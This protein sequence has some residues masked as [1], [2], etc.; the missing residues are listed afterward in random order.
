MK[1]LTF[2]S[3]KGGVG[4]TALLM[5]LAIQWADR[6][7]VVAV[8][9]MDLNAPGLSFH[10]WMDPHE[11]AA[12]QDYGTSDLLSTY[13]ANRDLE[14]GTFDFFPPSRLLR[15]V[16]PADGDKWGS[17]GRLLALPAGRVSLPQAATFDDITQHK[18]PSS[19]SSE[20]G[21][22]DR[23]DPERRSLRAFAK[24]FRED[25]AQF[26][27]PGSQRTID[28]LLIDCRTGYPDLADLAMGYLADRIVLVAGLN[29]Q[30]LKGLKLTLETLRPGRIPPGRFA[31]DA[32]VVF[33]PVSAHWRDSSE[34][35]AAI[36]EG[37]GVLEGA[38]L[39]L[40]DFE[41]IEKLPP[42][43]TLPYTPHLAVSDVPV[44]RERFLGRLH[45]YW[46][47]VYEIASEL[48]P[49]DLPEELAFDL[50]RKVKNLMGLDIVQIVEYWQKTDVSLKGKEVLPTLSVGNLPLAEIMRLPK[51]HWPLA[52]DREK[53]DQWYAKLPVKPGEEPERERFLD[54]LCASA[55]LG[56]EG[57][58]DLI[59]NWPELS[60]F[61]KDSL[62][63]ILAEEQTKLAASNSSQGRTILRRLAQS[64]R[65]WARLVLEDEKAGDRAM[66]YWPLEGRQ[67]FAAWESRP[68]YWFWLVENLV[69]SWPDGAGPHSPALIT[70]V[71]PA[72]VHLEQLADKDFSGGIWNDLGILLCDSLTRYNEA[73]SAY[74]KGLA[75]NAQS[76]Y[77]L[78]NLA[79]L[80]Y[81]V[82][83][84]ND[85]AESLYRR[86]LE[87]D[88]NSAHNLGNFALFMN[89]ARHSDDSYDEAER[90]YRRALEA[91]PNNAN[92]LGNFALFMNIVRH[93]D[94]SDN[95]AE[96]LYR[97]A[98]EADPN[99]ANNLRNFAIFMNIVRHS[100]DEAERLYR[101]AFEADPNNAN[102][103]G[104]LALFLLARGRREE[105]LVWLN[106]ALAR[107]ADVPNPILE[108]QCRFCQY[109]LGPDLERPKALARLRVLLDQ[110]TIRSP[111]WDFSAIIEQARQNGHPAIAWLNRLA[112][113]ISDNQPLALLEPWPDR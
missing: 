47:A 41:P 93:S 1:I 50:K 63:E 111:G 35:M 106:K 10:P 52:G 84:S 101:R 9:D 83:H 55:S 60:R 6:G 92:N 96:L 15:E 98:L 75:L 86:A 29:G 45:H 80:M 72:L 66:L 70:L 19:P 38:R 77:I 23:E 88:P 37:I 95:E 40:G 36:T 103:L 27:P 16:R 11:D 56:F 73:E 104:N 48:V 107:L 110:P 20:D 14:Q 109:A 34:S 7:R 108:A 61:Q 79:N 46:E 81:K 17:G 113:V 28:Y 2:Y 82:R 59:K 99:H 67:I 31:T 69:R 44:Y 54:D 25:L 39:P 94:D 62:L 58:R 64:Q 49:E 12:L 3:F 8:V 30:N 89:I 85:E 42:V 97:R 91:D 65:D 13:Y 57:K 71:K 33:S 43:H 76:A 21:Q 90:L 5:H 100:Y 51:W 18:V 4:R 78:G 32:V 22:K 87:A 74:R 112:Q 26:K 105:G 68:E 24:L 102:N 53:I